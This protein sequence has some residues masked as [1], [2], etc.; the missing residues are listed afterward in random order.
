MA[1]VYV[2][3]GSN[4]ERETSVRQGLARLGTS[5]G[6][7]AISP[8]YESV[9]VGM[10][11]PA[12]LNLV[13]GFHTVLSAPELAAELRV[14]EAECGRERPAD[15]SWQPRTLDLDLLTY[16]DQNYRD[17]NLD[18]PRDE[19]E[20]Y[21]FVLKPL[22]DLVP[23]GVY[24]RTGESYQSLWDTLGAEDDTLHPYAMDLDHGLGQEHGHP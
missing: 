7:M 14:I 15:G 1:L 21:P 9:A 5:Y 12:F 3:V 6:A 17:A 10:E 18:L 24:T 23:D 8:V 16:A 20:R 13:V 22:L 4:L 11:G 19:I 2:S